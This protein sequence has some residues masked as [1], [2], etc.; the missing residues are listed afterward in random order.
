VQLQQGG[1]MGFRKGILSLIYLS[2]LY[3]T[4]SMAGNILMVGVDDNGKSVEVE[5]P[6][7]KYKEN[8][9]KAIVGVQMSALPTLQK[10]SETSKG[11]ML[12]TAVLGI[13][14]NLEVGLGELKFGILPRFRVGFSNAKDPSVP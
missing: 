4:I 2:S 3:G 14:V 7:E 9:K 5:V 12:R 10:K 13:G 1:N 6:E 11:W 8:L